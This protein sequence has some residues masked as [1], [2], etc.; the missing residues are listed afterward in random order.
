MKL[1]ASVLLLGLLGF[2]VAFTAED[3]VSYGARD[4]ATISCALLLSMLERSPV[5]TEQQFYTWAQGYFAGH[6]AQ[7]ECVSPLPVHGAERTN[8]FRIIVEYCE[9][10]HKASYLQAV[11][12]LADSRCTGQK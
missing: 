1:F 6:A 12:S 7:E 10:N 3:D 8:A 2:Q 11:E 5:G 9:H 4:P